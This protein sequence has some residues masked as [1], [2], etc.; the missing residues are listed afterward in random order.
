MDPQLLPLM[1][2][3]PLLV[4]VAM[5]DLRSLRIP[6][7]LV[8]LCGLLF[9]A[10]ASVLGSGELL[11][12]LLAAGIALVVCFAL[13]AARI[14]GG[15]DAKFFPVFILF[16]PSGEVAL[17]M[18][19]LS[20]GIVA[21]AIAVSAAR[22][23]GSEERAPQWTALRKSSGFPMGVAFLAAALVFLSLAQA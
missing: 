18:L 2:A 7:Y 17:F 1:L 4:A 11:A 19:S 5:S 20:V 12:R 22:I 3:L 9:L 23:H 6:K 15:G 16:V 13:F 8:V 14:I 21:S 10:T